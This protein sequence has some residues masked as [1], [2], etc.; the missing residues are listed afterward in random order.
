MMT[1]QRIAIA[2]A[3][4]L[5]SALVARAQ[6]AH[7]FKISEVYI[8]CDGDTTSSYLNE[9]GEA[10]SWIEIT[11]ISYSTRDLRSCY[12][13]NNRE[14]LNPD[15]TPAQRMALMSPI[16]KG[17]PQTSIGARQCITFFAD[18]IDTRGTLHLN[19]TLTRA[20]DDFIALYDANGITLLDSVTLPSTVPF[21][22]SY[23]KEFSEENPQGVWVTR[24]ADEITANVINAT[25]K[26]M[27]DKVAEWKANDPHGIA[28]T[29]LAMCIVFCCLILLFVFFWFFGW[30]LNRLSQLDRLR[31][32]RALQQKANKLVV[33]AKEGSDTRGIEMENYVAAISLALHEYFGGTHD[34]ESGVITIQ[35][36]QTAWETRE[37]SL[38]QMPEQA[39]PEPGRVVISHHGAE[40][41]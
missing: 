35:H 26:G 2:V 41:Q 22:G 39:A 32:I 29:I 21:G 25:G 9:Y 14:V 34:I 15:L 18:G 20:V 8:A 30:L 1:N 7:D 11:N 10:C 33:M 3:A 23:A 27:E 40:N 36:H 17:D 4:L 6:G 12:L 37:Y 19:F 28:M 38:R 16:R 31:A 13:T 24:K 5:C